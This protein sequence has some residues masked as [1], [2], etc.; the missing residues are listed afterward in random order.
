MLHD[1]V[2]ME[3]MNTERRDT[4]IMLKHHNIIFVVG[5]IRKIVARA[6]EIRGGWLELIYDNEA[7]LQARYGTDTR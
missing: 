2:M 1:N 3:I 6:G 4:I 7:V 5:H